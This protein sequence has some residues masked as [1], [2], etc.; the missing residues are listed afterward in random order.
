[1]SEEKKSSKGRAKITAIGTFDEG[2]RPQGWLFDRPGRVTESDGKYRMGGYDADELRKIS[3]WS[4]SRENAIPD[5]FEVAAILTAVDSSKS[6][7]AETG[8]SEADV[9]VSAPCASVGAIAKDAKCSRDD[10]AIGGYEDQYFNFSAELA[11]IATKGGS[12]KKVRQTI[13]KLAT[14][15]V[16][17]LLELA[18][19]AGNFVEV[20][21]RVKRWVR[22]ERS[23]TPTIGE[24]VKDA[25]WVDVP[26]SEKAADA[27]EA[28]SQIAE[29]EADQEQAHDPHENISAEDF[30]PALDSGNIEGEQNSEFE[31]QA[32]GGEGF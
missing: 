23:D 3:V 31:K 28:Q 26:E 12:E 15:E 27:E 17:E 16:L 5:A 6:S 30:T 7:V 19:F 22:A 24:E 18:Q 1:M 13:I 32:E 21:I 10:R 25:E 2:G 14:H 4:E 11:D 20:E 9:Y 29:Q 8:A